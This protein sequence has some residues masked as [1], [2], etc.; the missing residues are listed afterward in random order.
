L[1]TPLLWLSSQ[2]TTGSPPTMRICG[3][4]AVP[5]ALMPPA[6]KDV[7]SATQAVPLNSAT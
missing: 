7:P 2:T 4:D 1:A 5:V 3:A 6:D